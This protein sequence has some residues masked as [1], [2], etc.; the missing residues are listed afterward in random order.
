[1]YFVHNDHLGTPIAVTDQSQSVVWE[2]EKEPFGNTTTSGSLQVRSRFP[3]QI[4]DE[5]TGLHYNYYRDYD[6]SLGRYIQSDPRGILL[7]FSDPQ[8]QLVAQMGLPDPDYGY[9]NGLNHLYGYAGQNPLMYTDPTGENPWIGPVVIAIWLF[10]DFTDRY[11]EPPP[12]QPQPQPPLFYDDGQSCRQTWNDQILP[13][14][15]LNVPDALGRWRIDLAPQF[16]R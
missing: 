12:V 5:E 1:M 7:D 10:E 14:D 9:V 2:A 3:G 6:P 15:P 11:F 13:I 4:F 16:R 8:R